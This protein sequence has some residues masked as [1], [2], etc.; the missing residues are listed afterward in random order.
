MYRSILS[1]LTITAFWI[2][3]VATSEDESDI[4]IESVRDLEE[5]VS[6]SR[7]E[8]NIGG[9]KSADEYFADGTYI[10]YEYDNFKEE[11]IPFPTEGGRKWSAHKGKWDE[12]EGGHFF[13]IKKQGFDNSGSPYRPSW[14]VFDNGK[15]CDVEGID[16]TTK[17]DWT[18][19][20]R[21][22]VLFIWESNVDCSYPEVKVNSK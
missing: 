20:E 13:Y 1:L 3:A 21:E 19:F 8:Q 12:S 17:S 16:G 4:K 7:F 5:Y 9:Y 6:D 18:S 10:S 14:L 15:F 11:W 22:G 2:T